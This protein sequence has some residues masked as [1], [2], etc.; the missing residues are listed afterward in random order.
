MTEPLVD[1]TGAR[2]RRDEARRR[3][4]LTVVGVLVGVLVLV[5]GVVWLFQGS[6][7]LAA[8]RVR[9]EGTQVL[10]PDAVAQAAAVPLGGPLASVDT[11]AAQRRVTEAL[12]AVESARVERAWP[13]AVLIR[14]VE[15]RPVVAIPLG[16]V[17]VWVDAE[18]VAFHRT[19]KPPEGVMVAEGNVSEPAVLEALGKVAASLPGP[20]R[21]KAVRIGATSPDSVV[22]TLSDRRRVV[23]GSP[24]QPELK[25]QVLVPLLQV[26]ASEYDVSAPTNPTTR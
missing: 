13:D 17:H 4:R 7:W 8:S 5:G 22:I 10:T 6:P 18:G 11:D 12:P 19:P 3:R 1:V 15:R 26:K 20:V 23:W 14:V 24:D 21:E 16:G 25:A 2:R 9:V